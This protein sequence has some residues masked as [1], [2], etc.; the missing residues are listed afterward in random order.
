M[1][2]TMKTI[3]LII[4]VALIA[5]RAD[6][7]QPDTPQFKS[8]EWR[9]TMA[10]MA[11]TST[12]GLEHIERIAVAADYLR[13][14]LVLGLG[15]LIG[16]VGRISHRELTEF[17]GLLNRAAQNHPNPAQDQNPQST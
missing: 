9:Q 12:Q 11:T 3:K 7:Q 10:D 14:A 15:I 4:L 17:K 1:E 13:L 8:P 6:A 16:R 5:A 2:I